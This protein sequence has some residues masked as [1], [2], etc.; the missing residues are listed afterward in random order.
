MYLNLRAQY[1]RDS[2]Q[3]ITEALRVSI[4]IEKI[5]ISLGDPVGA[6]NFYLKY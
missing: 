2:Q 4:E 6:L 1:P 3:L 5:F